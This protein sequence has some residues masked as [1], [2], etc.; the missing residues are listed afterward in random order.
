MPKDI[1]FEQA[2]AR[3]EEIAGLLESD[4]VTLEESVALYS[5]GMEL[6]K[7]CTERLAS[8]RQKITELTP[9]DTD[10]GDVSDD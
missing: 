4:N 5:E 3:L 7:L 9:D 2:V 8:A 10:D 6:A 1:T